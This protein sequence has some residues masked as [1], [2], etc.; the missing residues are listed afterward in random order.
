MPMDYTPA[1]AHGP[2]GTGQRLIRSC[3][4]TRCRSRTPA[5]VTPVRD[6][7][8]ILQPAQ[9]RQI[10][11]SSVGD[12]QSADGQLLQIVQAP[13][14]RQPLV[15]HLRTVHVQVLQVR[16]FREP[17]DAGVGDGGVVEVEHRRAG[18]ARSDARPASVTCVEQRFSVWK[19]F[20]PA[21][22]VRS[23]SVNPVL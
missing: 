14:L 20:S 17:R 13:Q 5:S 4:S 8:R 6:S 15:R 19:P 10:R 11:Q 2:P 21:R 3:G 16:Q 7:D 18:N 23:S 12:R 9:P 22:R 1:A